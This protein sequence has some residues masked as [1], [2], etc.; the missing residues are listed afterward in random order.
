MKAQISLEFLFSVL[1][2]IIILQILLGAQDSVTKDFI[3]GVNET[4]LKMQADEVGSYCNLIYFNWKSLKID[5][6][7]NIS[8]RISGNR[9]LMSRNNISVKAAC[10]SP[11]LGIGETL[12]VSGERKWF[13]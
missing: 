6:P 12:E 11:S 4:K 3:R 7:R 13:K 8:F 2:L 1:A 10:L 9:I 5:F